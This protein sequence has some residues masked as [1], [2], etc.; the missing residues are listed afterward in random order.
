MS[1]TNTDNVAKKEYID[2]LYEIEKAFQEAKA[3]RNEMV[4][5][6][7]TEV[8][9]RRD[10]TGVEFT[11]I[12]RLTKIRLDLEAAREDHETLEGD[13]ATIDFLYEGELDVPADDEV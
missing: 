12:K 8:K 6:L 4:K 11:E 1:E 7:G 9:T 2:R 3:E 5:D 13:I 10:E